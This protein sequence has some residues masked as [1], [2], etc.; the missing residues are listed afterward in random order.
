MV[1]IVII[2]MTNIYCNVKVELK[3]RL[4]K[5]KQRRVDV[6]WESPKGTQQ[7]FFHCHVC[8][9]KSRTNDEERE[10]DTLESK[11]QGLRYIISTLAGLAFFYWKS[12]VIHVRSVSNTLYTT[13]REKMRW[14]IVR[15]DARNHFTSHNLIE[16]NCTGY[17][18]A[19]KNKYKGGNGKI[20]NCY[21]AKGR[22][23]KKRKL[24]LVV[25]A[26]RVCNFFTRYWYCLAERRK[27]VQEKSTK[28]RRRLC[29]EK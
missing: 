6:R 24:M 23:K 1:E 3:I 17:C 14:H 16:G 29:V 15:Q 4:R 20:T 13:Q 22:I 18:K 8:G 9:F 7:E 21:C 28:E 10:V 27:V 19:L 11:I 26:A 25:R 12:K 2:S 5:S